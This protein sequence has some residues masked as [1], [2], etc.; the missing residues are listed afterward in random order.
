M[1]SYPGGGTVLGDDGL[2]SRVSSNGKAV[3]SFGVAGTKFINLTVL[4]MAVQK[5]GKIVLWGT[6]L[7]VASL[8]GT[9]PEVMR[10]LSN[11]KLDKTFGNAGIVK[12]VFPDLGGGIAPGSVAVLANGEIVVSAVQTDTALDNPGAAEEERAVVARFTPKGVLDGSFASGGIDLLPATLPGQTAGNG[13]VSANIAVQP[14]GSFLTVYD[15]GNGGIVAPVPPRVYRFAPDGTP[16]TSFGTMGFTD[17]PAAPVGG[18]Y[19]A[20]V[21]P[22]GKIELVGGDGTATSLSLLNADGSI[23]TQFGTA[24]T[25]AGLAGDPIGVFQQQGGKIVTVTDN[26]WDGGPDDDIA[27]ARYGLDGTLDDSFGYHGVTIDPQGISGATNAVALQK[28]KKILDAGS[29]QA[30]VAG[31]PN[32]AAMVRYKPDGTLDTT[33]GTAGHVMVQIGQN[34][35]F[36]SVAVAPNGEIYASASGDDGTP[37]AS[38]VYVLYRFKANGALDRRFGDKGRVISGGPIGDVKVLAKG[39]VLT[40]EPVGGTA[41]MSRYL[42]SGKPDPQ[43]GTAGAVQLPQSF[44]GGGPL[45]PEADGS[46]LVAS[47]VGGGGLAKYTAQGQPDASFG[48]VGNALVDANYLALVPG[49]DIVAVNFDS[50]S[51]IRLLPNGQPDTSF[52]Q[53]D[54]PGE[55]SLAGGALPLQQI[56]GVTVQKNGRILLAAIENTGTVPPPVGV[57]GL[58]ATG[59]LDPSFSAQSAGTPG[60]AYLMQGGFDGNTIPAIVPQPDGNI[61]VAVNYSLPFSPLDVASRLFR[62]LGS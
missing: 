27:L 15:G 43:F 42:P 47:R 33:F 30:P 16:D 11:G 45:L 49:G 46:I 50:V 54:D 1:A 24:G 20:F 22:D 59:K 57:V 51:V 3:K 25:V 55:V 31:L 39:D 34:A 41:V 9:T 4:S 38:P 52:G 12:P 6:E 35:A 28:D 5:D 58:D 53:P 8:P 62:I 19:R 23:D 14:D 48:T 61:L 32:E 10:L 60:F 36:T 56:Q 21:R 17:L 29:E 7:P 40:T 13:A 44:A 2:V 18:G 26:S 37:A